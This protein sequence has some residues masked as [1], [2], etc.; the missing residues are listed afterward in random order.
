MLRRP[1][2]I[3]AYLER[4]TL[5]ARFKTGGLWLLSHS[6]VMAVIAPPHF[7]PDLNTP[8]RSL[9]AADIPNRIDID[10]DHQSG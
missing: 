7:Y 8:E 6:S 5:V 2:Y 1:C 3:S 10:R 4:G 9:V